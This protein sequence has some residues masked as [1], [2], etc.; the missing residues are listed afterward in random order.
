[1]KK[2]EGTDRRLSLNLTKR[3][4]EKKTNIDN[5]EDRK[6][7]ITQIKP[8]DGKE[9]KLRMFGLNGPEGCRGGNG[10]SRHWGL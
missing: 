7:A 8:N 9:I 10:K 6:H 5:R 2:N 4:Q 3:I 1:M